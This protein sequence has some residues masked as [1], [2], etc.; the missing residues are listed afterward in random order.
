VKRIQATVLIAVSLALVPLS[1]ACARGAGGLTWGEQYFDGEFSNYDVQASTSGGFGYAVTR[2][3]TRIG[4]FA[5]AMHSDVP[6]SSFDA[7]FVG[8]ITGQE[9]RAGIFVAAANLWTGIGGIAG[10]SVIQGPA[11]FAFFGE[12]T[13][14]VGISLF[15]GTTMSAYA[16]M[17]AVAP[18]LITGQ[19]FD[20]VLYTP[21]FGIRVGWGG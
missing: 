19:L 2:G 11:T 14:E 12:A 18:V 21:T 10:S 17:Q 5:L 7:G 8:T 9:T 15:P 13:V 16:G 6:G 4:G 1:M 3:G 20:R